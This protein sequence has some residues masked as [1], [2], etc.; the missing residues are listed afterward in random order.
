MGAILIDFLYDNFWSI[1][2]SIVFTTFVWNYASRRSKKRAQR[3]NMI[4]KCTA[5]D[6]IGKASIKAKTTGFLDIIVTICFLVLCFAVWLFF[7]NASTLIYF[8]LLLSITVLF[9]IYLKW[10][11]SELVECPECGKFD[12]MIPADSPKSTEKN[13]SD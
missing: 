12:S 3:I 9:F 1:Y 4:R 10:S 13:D 7:N 5:C 8:I 6:F 11:W 2:I